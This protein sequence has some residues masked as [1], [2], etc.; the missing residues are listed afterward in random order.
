[1]GY[2]L[3]AANRYRMFGRKDA[4]RLPTPDERERFLP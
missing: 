3:V 2:R 1:L 4:C